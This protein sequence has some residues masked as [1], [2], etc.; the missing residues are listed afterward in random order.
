MFSE[1]RIVSRPVFDIDFSVALGGAGG[2]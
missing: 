2:T 1:K